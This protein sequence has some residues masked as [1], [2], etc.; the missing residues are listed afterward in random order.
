MRRVQ[1]L[2]AGSEYRLKDGRWVYAVTVG[3]D[4]RG[5][6]VR[7]KV[8]AT[9]REKLR[10]KRRDFLNKLWSDR[11]TD[12]QDTSTWLVHWLEKTAFGQVSPRVHANYRSII[13][14][15]LI[16]SIGG[17]TLAALGA[18]EVREALDATRDKGVSERTVQITY[19]VL[20]R[21]LK[22]AV[23]EGLID[24]NPCDAVP[25]PR[26]VSKPRRAL[27]VVEARRVL[28]AAPD[29]PLGSLFTTVLLTGARKAEALGLEGERIAGGMID[30]S[31]QLQEIPWAHGS[32]CAC[33]DTSAWECPTR[34][35]AL[36]PG[37]E[38]RELHGA[39][40]LVR[41][42]TAASTRVLPI[43]GH[44]HETLSDAPGTGL[45]WSRGGLPLSGRE[46]KRQWVDLLR[47]ARV[48]QVD[49]HSARHTTASL[50]LEAG[51]APEVIAQI[52]GHSSVVSTKRYLHVGLGQKMT[53]LRDLD[54]L[55]GLG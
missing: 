46:A 39:K 17:Y 9:S 24:R 1:T 44:L 27:S 50:L 41:P 51:V 54:D 52:M 5:Q 19:G 35:H 53:A 20:S 7:R 25:R 18:E 36:P 12:D 21:A 42:K 40:M 22:Q 34:R 15:H 47:D 48:S 2:G 13:S 30:V 49:L 31:W 6:Q 16:P 26:A 28:A 4:G 10:A 45:V 3:Y 43:V 14:R 23:A 33:Q 37:Y 8:T 55:L 29:H 11:E 32:R 38:A